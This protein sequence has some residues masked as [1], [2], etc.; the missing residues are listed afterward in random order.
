MEPENLDPAHRDSS[1]MNRVV[2]SNT[3]VNQWQQQGFLLLNNVF[4]DDDI[5]AATSDIMKL[6]ME[7]KNCDDFEVGDGMTFPTGLRSLDSLTLDPNLIGAVKQVLNSP[8]IR[9]SQAE[10]W[11]KVAYKETTP[12]STIDRTFSNQ[13]QRMHMDFPNH[14]LLH[15]PQWD[16]PEAVAVIIYLSDSSE[17]GGPTSVVPKLPPPAVDELYQWPYS[18]MPGFGRIPWRND[19]SAVESFLREEFPEVAAFRQ[20]LYARE[21]SIT[22]R[23]GTVL[24]YRHDLWHR[25]TPLLPGA[26]RYVQNLVFKKPNCDWLNN[27]NKGTAYH[28]YRR[29]QYVEK[30]IARISVEQ[31]NC[32]GIPLP[33]HAYWTPATLMATKQRYGDFGIDMTPYEEGKQQQQQQDDRQTDTHSLV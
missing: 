16:S 10:T 24:L 1:L 5:T 12:C 7:K 18:H 13:D 22:Y 32:L 19:R 11:K 14:T 28:M 15:P 8:E 21:T 25:G 26:T 23:P 20:K 17:C 29:D 27:W 2:L 4:T 33:G 30:L 9:M 3:Q 6:Q 31:R